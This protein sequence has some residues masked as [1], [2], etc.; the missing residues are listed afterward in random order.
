MEWTAVPRRGVAGREG[1]LHELRDV[2]RGAG[3]VPQ[4][5]IADA[6][7]LEVGCVRPG[8]IQYLRGS[9]VRRIDKFREDETRADQADLDPERFELAAQ[10][11]GDRFERMLR[12]VID[13][14]QRPRDFPRDGT[15][16]DD[17]A[18]A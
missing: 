5:V 2:V 15:D 9:G 3:Y 14:R 4:P 11:I 12:G 13:A 1:F 18:G 6:K 8:V 10:A 7:P 16:V 17:A